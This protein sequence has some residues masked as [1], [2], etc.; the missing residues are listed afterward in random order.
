MECMRKNAHIETIRKELSACRDLRHHAYIEESLS[1]AT[2]AD[3]HLRLNFFPRAARAIIDSQNGYRFCS[4]P[5]V[6]SSAAGQSEE[7]VKVADAYV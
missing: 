7:I 5:C 6:K 2:P 3:V 1:F 4:R